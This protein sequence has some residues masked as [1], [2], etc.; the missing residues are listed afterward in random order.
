MVSKQVK[1]YI[2]GEL[3][4]KLEKIAEER[5]VSVPALVKSL[6]LQYLGTVGEPGVDDKIKY[7]MQRVQQISRE[8]GRIEIELAL[9][10]RKVERHEREL[11]EIERTY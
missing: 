3:Y 8:V 6:V 7:L 2:S 5:G 4:E 10:K 11:R 9:L 1:F